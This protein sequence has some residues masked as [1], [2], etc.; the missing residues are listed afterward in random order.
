MS[1][2]LSNLVATLGSNSTNGDGTSPDGL[3]LSGN[4]LYGTA[5][6]GGSSSSGTVFKMNTDGTGFTLLHAFTATSGSPSTNSDGKTPNTG[7]MLSGNTL[8]GT[9]EYGGSSGQGTVFAVNTDGT[10]FTVLHAFTAADP[11]TG[12]N[13]DGNGPQ[14]GLVLSGNTMYGTASFGGTNDNGTVFSLIPSIHP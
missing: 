2:V 5:S 9:A 14:G 7:L 13:S 6:G 11:N 12:A 1:V 8:Y 4:T 3:V 10:D